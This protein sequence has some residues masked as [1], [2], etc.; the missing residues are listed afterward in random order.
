M[1][2]RLGLIRAIFVL[3]VIGAAVIVA[4][5]VFQPARQAGR[6]PV[7]EAGVD[8]AFPRDLTMPVQG[9][10]PGDIEDTFNQS[11]GTERK[12]EATDILAPRGTPVVA[13]EDGTIKKLFFSVPGGK[14]I[15]QFDPTEQYAYYYAHLD[16]YATGIQEGMAVKRGAVIGYV[17]TTGNAPEATPHLHF[18]IFEL[19]PEKRWWEGTPINPYPILMALKN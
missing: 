14:T 15:Y 13:V 10:G 6:I 3:G 11:R 7:V 12:H 1:I 2:M 5:A 17:G 9:V 4:L 16:R 8:K 19:G 18:G